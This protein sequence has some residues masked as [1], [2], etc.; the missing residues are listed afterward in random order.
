MYVIFVGI[1][2]FSHQ[3]FMSYFIVFLFLLGVLLAYFV[4][5]SNMKLMDKDAS[6]FGK[7]YKGYADQEDAYKRKLR[8]RRGLGTLIGYVMKSDGFCSKGE[9]Q[10]AKDFLNKYYEPFEVRTTLE[11]IKETIK[12]DYNETEFHSCVA[13]INA[14]FDAKDK[15]K[16]ANLMYNIASTRGIDDNR[17]AFLERILNLLWIE[18]KEQQKIKNLYFVSRKYRTSDSEETNNNHQNT[19]NRTASNNTNIYESYY[20]VLGL[21]PGASQTAIKSAYRKLA[22][23]YHPDRV[24]NDT[25][26]AVNTEKFKRITEAYNVLSKH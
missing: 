15:I 26:K 21:K 1:F 18:K 4:L 2:K 19:Y 7:N 23:M 9:L 20:D 16:I 3:Y 6:G 13:D 17:W 12:S 24:Q 5:T 11:T 25:Q 22:K 10:K 8:A 14:E